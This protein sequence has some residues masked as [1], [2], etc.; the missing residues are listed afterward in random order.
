M[1][2]R[3]IFFTL[4]MLLL[5][6][7]LA[8]PVDAQ[9]VTTHPEVILKNVPFDITVSG[10]TETSLWYEV[11]TSEGTIL[12]AGTVDPHDS[13]TARGLTVASKAELPL[14][15]LV[16]DEAFEID[17]TLTSGWYSILPP[18]VA[19]ILALLIREVVTALFVGVWLGALA[20]GGFRHGG[21]DLA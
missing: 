6:A 13:S 18:L 15:V 2:L 11:R 16:G 10:G 17:P 7:P 9:E 8:T 14:T 5:V 4:A 20:V 19:I 12:D 21:P 1:R 3:S